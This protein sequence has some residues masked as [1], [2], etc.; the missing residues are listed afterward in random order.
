[1]PGRRAFDAGVDNAAKILGAYRPWTYDEIKKIM[2]QRTGCSIDHHTG[3]WVHKQLKE[4]YNAER[5]IRWN[6]RCRIRCGAWCISC[7]SWWK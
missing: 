7:K 3:D 1:M 6:A 4:R 2:E 5:R